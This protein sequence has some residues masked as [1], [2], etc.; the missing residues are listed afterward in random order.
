MEF[1]DE[2]DFEKI[3]E[4]DFDDIPDGVIDGTDYIN[5][6]EGIVNDLS[7]LNLNDDKSR[8]LFMMR[9]INH[10]DFSEEES[11]YQVISALC[12]HIISLLGIGEQI[13]DDFMTHYVDILY[14]ETIPSLKTESGGMPYWN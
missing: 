2:K 4:Q 11:V 14:S 12:Y 9:I 3:I 10:V 5:T 1:F 6:F 7:M 8:I 13:T